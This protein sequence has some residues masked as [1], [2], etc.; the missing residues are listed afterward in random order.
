MAEL[1]LTSELG[2]HLTGVENMFLQVEHDQ[3]LMTICSV[4]IFTHRLDTTLVLA[5]LDNLCAHYPRFYLVPKHGSRLETPVWSRP[6]RKWEPKDQL[7]FHTLAT[8]STLCLQKYI[9]SQY[10]E[11]FD[12]D[13]PLWQVHIITGLKN[14]QT[15]VL[16][17]AHHC[18]SDGIGIM[19]AVLAT[20]TSL[21]PLV[22]SYRRKRHLKE[23]TV[24]RQSIIIQLIHWLIWAWQFF[25]ITIHQL[26]HEFWAATLFV[27]PILRFPFRSSSKQQDWF[28]YDGD[29][30][31][32]KLMAW[33]DD[34]PLKDIQHVQHTLGGPGYTLNDVMLMVFART[35]QRY[36]LD[37]IGQS[38][39]TTLRIVIPLSLRSPTDWSMA[40]KATGGIIGL[41]LPISLKQV[42]Q[43][44]MVLKQSIMPRFTFHGLIQYVFRYFPFLIGPRWM[45]HWYADLP[46]AI[47][48]NIAGPTVPTFFGGQEIIGFHVLPP[49]A[50]KGCISVGLV[51]YGD[52]VNLSLLTDNHQDYPDLAN[53]L[54]HLFVS[55]FNKILLETKKS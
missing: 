54:C 38:P 36:K 42:H 53:I 51:S 7:V 37:R 6:H 40:N 23:T 3:R 12:F 44:M 21:D 46:H 33:T 18:M 22:E 39:S 10:I 8:P 9:S 20:T 48:T 13:K 1:K 31:R 49:Q 25:I 4:W 27:T 14:N 24:P 15:A 50:G 52:R 17:K 11:P 2:R 34:I 16:W 19:K 45:Q 35:V 5:S 32:A 47:F 41:N 26:R 28:G 29:Q 55:E 30:T 43:R